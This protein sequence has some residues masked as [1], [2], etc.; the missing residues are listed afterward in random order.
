MISVSQQDGLEVRLVSVQLMT[1]GGG[2]AI[3]EFDDEI[4]ELV[5]AEVVTDDD[6][7]PAMTP[8]IATPAEAKGSRKV[9]ITNRC[10]VRQQFPLQM[11]G[12]VSGSR[13]I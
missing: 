4:D 6:L 5:E 7:P 12:V 1:T 8:S 10:I 3:A 11:E 13:L 9:G 2:D